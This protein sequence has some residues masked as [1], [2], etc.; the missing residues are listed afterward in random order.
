MT[1]AEMK[2]LLERLT[3]DQ[4]LRLKYLLQEQE[5]ARWSHPRNVRFDPRTKTWERRC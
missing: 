2:G 3:G 4:L 5:R 1:E